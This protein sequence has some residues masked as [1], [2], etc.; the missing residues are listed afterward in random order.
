LQRVI[1]EAKTIEDE[2]WIE[3]DWERDHGRERGGKIH[4]IAWTKQPREGR[5]TGKALGAGE[6]KIFSGDQKL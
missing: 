6:K 3:K 2:S 5:K 4:K 1:L